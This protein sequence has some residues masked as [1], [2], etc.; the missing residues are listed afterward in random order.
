MSSFKENFQREESE[1]LKHDDVA[2]HYFSVAILVVVLIP[3]TYFLIIRPMMVG[4]MIINM[5]LKNCKCEQCQVRLKERQAIYRFA[6]INKWLV[7]KVCFV[8]VL[9]ACC[10]YS[11]LLVKDLDEIKGFIPHEILGIDVDAPLS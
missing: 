10:G 4:E 2:F 1:N 9:W 6:F 11:Y 7:L 8:A 3:L 5:S